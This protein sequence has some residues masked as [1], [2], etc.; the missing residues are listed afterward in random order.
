MPETLRTLENSRLLYILMFYLKASKG[1]EQLE[2]LR[3]VLT[4]FK[5]LD[6]RFFALIYLLF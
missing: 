1:F 6:S 3:R 4:I 2:N 5:K